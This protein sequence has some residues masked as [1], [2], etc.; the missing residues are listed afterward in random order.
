[1]ISNK[2][3]VLFYHIPRTG[4]STVEFLFCNMDWS[5]IDHRTKHPSLS[6]FKNE[7]KNVW[8]EYSKFTIVRNPFEWVRSLY[9]ENRCPSLN[10]EYFCKNIKF[11]TRNTNK[12]FVYENI[13]GNTFNTIIKNEFDYVLRYEDLSENNFLYITNKFNLEPANIK[14]MTYKEHHKFPKPKHTQ[15]TFEIVKN[16]FKEDFEKF[17]PELLSITFEDVKNQR[18]EYKKNIL[19]L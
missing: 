2:H 5:F 8:D 14:L 17:Y 10:F 9:S 1:M 18:Y 4:G 19:Q 7:Y 6:D 3:K 13:K 11:D 15:N 12:G 16:K